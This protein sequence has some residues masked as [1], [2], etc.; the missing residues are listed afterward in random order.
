MSES[1]EAY[2]LAVKIEARAD[3]YFFARYMFKSMRGYRW[4]H[5]WHHR[6]ICDALMRVYRG[7][8][9]RLIINVPPRYSKTELAVVNFIAW[10]LGLAPDAEFI[11]VSYAAALAVNNAG[12]TKRL[13]EHEAYRRIF[14]ELQL[15]RD[16]K[17]KGE[18]RTTAGGVVY[19]QGEGGT[20]TGFG[21]GKLRPGFGGA[22]IID[23]IHK[24]DE[25]RSDK[26][27]EGVI[28]WFKN[29]LESRVNSPDTPIIVIGQ[30]LHERD[31]PGWLLGG[32][33]GEKWELVKLS[34]IQP[35]HKALWPEKHDIAMLSR[36]KEKKPYEF[37][38]QYDQDPSPRDGGLFKREWFPIA[39]AAP[40]GGT[41]VRKWDL[42]ATEEKIGGDPDWTVG[43]LMSRCPDGFFWVRDVI[44]LRGSPHQVEQAIKNTASQD[45]KAVTIHLNQDPGQAGKSQISALTRMLAGWPVK[46]EIESGS[47]ETRATPFSAQCEAG[48]VRLVR[49]AWN[50]DFITEACA[51]PNA[52]HDDQVDSAS[53]AFNHLAP[54]SG[55]EG[56]LSWAADK[57][58]PAEPD[59][60]EA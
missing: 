32:G 8:C 55:L 48:N 18:W 10:A 4:L 13:V 24:A 38:G 25:A 33:N 6:E 12:N 20:I 28:E 21:A 14:P 59:K 16:S 31:L 43:T 1:A 27:R 7:E 53:G 2:N 54:G 35:N 11:H 50:E 51:F 39:D 46:S 45:G 34:A 52:S 41:I 49:G 17:A 37:A 22:I 15:R 19:A 29:T 47:K 42:A 5:N 30:R 60:Q 56:W 9:K 40:A 57:L 23:D 36:M 58:S 26:I 44:R 3:L